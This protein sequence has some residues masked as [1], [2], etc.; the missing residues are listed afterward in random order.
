MQIGPSPDFAREFRQRRRA[1]H[2]HGD[3][4]LRRRVAP[5]PHH[6]IRTRRVQ[7]TRHRAAHVAETGESDL[8]S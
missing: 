4:S 2:A 8:V 7:M 3:G 5:I 1:P 6:H